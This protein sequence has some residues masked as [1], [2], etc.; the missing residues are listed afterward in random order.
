MVPDESRGDVSVHGFWKWD[1]FALFDMQIVNLDAVSYLCQTS[2]KDLASVE[3]RK[4]EKYLYPS[5][6]LT[7]SFTT[8]LYSAESIPR[9][10]TVAVQQRLAWIL[11]NIMN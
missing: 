6:D 7:S 3:K 11:S 1:T 5:L 10:E 9:I 8:M 2:V 4:K